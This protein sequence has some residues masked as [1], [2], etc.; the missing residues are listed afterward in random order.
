MS[1]APSTQRTTASPL[2]SFAG[3]RVLVTG[4]AGGL[5]AAVA[6]HLAAR[7]AALALT[8]VPS[9]RL[10]EVLHDVSDAV[11]IPADLRADAHRL[12]ALAAEALG[13]LDGV[14]NAAGIMQTVP[15]AALEP[16]DWE[17]IISVNLTATFRL[18][19][20]AGAVM[21]TGAIVS[22]ASVA[23]RSGRP[24]AAHYAASK[25]AVLSLTKSAASALA[26]RVRVNAV[27]PGVIMT[28]MWERIIQD[29]DSEFGEGAGEA[30]F[31]QVCRAAALGRAGR[32]DE[33]A[34]VVAF[35]LS[36]EASFVT[37]QAVNVCGG[38]EMD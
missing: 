5:G 21:T 26:P 34:S 6:E 8:D 14:V 31:A 24:D 19:Q 10:G 17:R 12:P 16:A 3:R 28:P 18:V 25:S 23:A 35:L 36:D 29:R 37:G 38:L 13:G 4:A 15:F 11:M 20:A 27:C 30:Y 22:I 2:P 9:S 1:I 33:I 7:G 32:P